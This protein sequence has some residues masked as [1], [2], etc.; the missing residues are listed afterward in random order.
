MDSMYLLNLVEWE[1]KVILF[2][3]TFVLFEHILRSCPF[4][5]LNKILVRSHSILYDLQ[6]LKSTLIF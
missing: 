2:V 4:L 6:V 3:F 5:L 1:Q